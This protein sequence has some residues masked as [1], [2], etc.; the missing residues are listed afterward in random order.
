MTTTDSI[1]RAREA[2][3]AAFADPK[4][5]RSLAVHVAR[6]LGEIDLA[7][8]I[9]ARTWVRTTIV[10]PID[11]YAGSVHLAAPERR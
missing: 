11:P 10:S 4:V 6:A 3:L 8:V 2:L 7:L 1:A 9:D 5:P